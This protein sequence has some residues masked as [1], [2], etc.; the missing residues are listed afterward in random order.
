MTNYIDLNTYFYNKTEIEEELATKS[1]ITHNHDDIY[2]KDSD[3]AT[4]YSYIDNIISEINEKLS[5]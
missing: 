3:A 1:D 5:E 2:L 4:I